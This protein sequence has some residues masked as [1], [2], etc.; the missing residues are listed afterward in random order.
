MTVWQSNTNLTLTAYNPSRPVMNPLDSPSSV[1]WNM[2]VF[3][4]LLGHKIQKK[5]KKDLTKHQKSEWLTFLF[6]NHL[7]MITDLWA[8]HTELLCCFF[9][10]I[11]KT[12]PLA[13]Q[14]VS[15]I[16]CQCHQLSSELTNGT[17]FAFITSHAYLKRIF[18]YWADGN[19]DKICSA[20]DWK[21]L[22]LIGNVTHDEPCNSEVREDKEWEGY[23][24]R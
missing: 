3:T 2:D 11:H 7:K 1:S 17:R 20:S 19:C 5:K 15:L 9:N 16:L 6:R 13:K 10:S 8:W 21:T 22:R 14:T 4:V 24:E 12:L 23:K 18:T